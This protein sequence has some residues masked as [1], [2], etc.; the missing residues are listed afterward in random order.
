MQKNISLLKVW[1]IFLI[2]WIIS[3]LHAGYLNDKTLA[4]EFLVVMITGFTS[5]RY[6]QNNSEFLR[7]LTVGLV[8]VIAYLNIPLGLKEVGLIID[9]INYLLA[10]WG[11][12]D[13]LNT[14]IATHLAF[15]AS[16]IY[17]L[18]SALSSSQ[19]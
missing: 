14:A 16:S 10:G 13:R 5:L 8:S 15:C 2:L 9:D 19:D 7:W 3:N 12:R 11:W 1:K 17:L 4:I 6:D 18:Y